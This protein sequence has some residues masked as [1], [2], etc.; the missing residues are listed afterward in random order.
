MKLTRQAISV[1]IVAL[2]ALMVVGFNLSFYYLHNAAKRT[3]E[4]SL[5][6]RLLGIGRTILPQIASEV[7]SDLEFGDLSLA[8]VVR[9][10]RYFTQIEGSE[11]LSGINLIDNDDHDLLNWSDSASVTELLLPLYQ[12]A[13]TE[14]RL[15]Q[16]T[17]SEIYQVGDR[18][19]KSAFC[20]VG[21]DSVV[22]VLMVESGFEFFESF[23]S[24]KRNIVPINIAAVIFLVLVAVIIV[25]LNRKLVAAEK[26]VVS[27]TALAQMG[28]MAAIIAH[29]VRNPLAIMKAT[30]ERIKKKYGSD[31]RDELFDFIQ[32]ESDRLSEISGRY[33]QF[34]A[35][36]AGKIVAESLQEV[37]EAVAGGLRRDYQS[38]G[39]ELRLDMKEDAAALPLDSG[40]LRHI[41]INLLRNALEACDEGNEVSLSSRVE[42]RSQLRLVVSDN[43]PG[44]DKRQRKQ[45]F[46]PF[47]TTKAKGSGLGLFVVKRLVE[48]LHGRIT[49]E[50]EVGSGTRFVIVIP[51]GDDG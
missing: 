39:V 24:Y 1:A 47:Y 40:R 5:G 37:V 20:P 4:Q 42:G 35:P 51:V 18:Y 19:F 36:V 26:M 41:L 50:S 27:Q 29:E 7:E 46:D 38:Q 25:I 3:L 15:G 6:D 43:G 8:T 34:A 49:I 17:T 11:E 45:A 32:E 21:G 13:L 14:A 16:A 9:L 31:S 33:L 44:L 30:A 23:A 22:A 2:L 10:D 12:D 28:Q 48:E